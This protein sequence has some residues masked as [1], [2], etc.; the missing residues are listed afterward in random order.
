MY[1]RK[2]GNEIPDD[3]VFCS[4]CGT[5]IAAV[6]ERKESTENNVDRNT[7]SVS[8]VAEGKRHSFSPIVWVAVSILAIVLAVLLIYKLPSR[9]VP[10][11]VNT[12]VKNEV[13]EENDALTEEQV[14]EEKIDINEISASC[15]KLECY[16][17]SGALESTGSGFVAF[18]KD[19]IV[20][21]YHVIE[22]HPRRVIVLS[23]S[24]E[25]YE[26]DRILVYNT[27]IDI[28]ILH[29]KEP[30]ELIPL[31]LSQKG[32]ER[33][34]KVIAIGSPLGLINMVSEGVVSGFTQIGNLSAIQFT[35]SI[36]HGSS[37]GVL[38]NNAGEVVGVTFASFTEGQNMNIAIPIDYVVALYNQ[39]STFDSIYVKD[40]C[41]LKA[42]S[43]DYISAND[44]LFLG[45]SITIQGYVSSRFARESDRY[46]VFLVGE[47][48]AVNGYVYKTETEFN[49]SGAW[50]EEWE[51]LKNHKSV[52]FNYNI[53]KGAQ[54]LLPGSYVSVTGVFSLSSMPVGDENYEYYF[55]YV[56]K[57][58]QSE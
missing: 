8:V 36:S 53:P 3:S 33:S 20:T 28:A 46:G 5:P 29:I 14:V 15:M 40:F 1:C 13:T 19:I 55:L 21:N 17:I 58:E 41:K 48:S 23:E 38:L 57:V 11:E 31:S 7:E 27:D 37:G 22:N 4:K 50:K 24:G 26:I 52:Y 39:R 43:I 42:Y 10:E 56:S 9:M 18:S 54:I 34:D 44:S 6:F 49:A 51:K 47:E 35:A 2:C 30:T 45:N 12:N 16:D 25:Q 32:V